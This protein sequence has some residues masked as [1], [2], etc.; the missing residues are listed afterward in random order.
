MGHAHHKSD[1]QP[2]VDGFQDGSIN[3]LVCSLFLKRGLNLPLITTIINAAGGEFYSAPLQI[4]GRGVRKHASKKVVY[5]E[6]IQDDGVF[7]GKHS[8]QRIKYYK[9]QA[10]KLRDLR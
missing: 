10:L 2:Q 7:I 4:A 8:K 9:T 5:L 6:D 1:Y 3:V